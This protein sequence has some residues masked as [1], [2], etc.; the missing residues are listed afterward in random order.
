[1]KKLSIEQLRNLAKVKY[2]V[3]Y[4]VSATG[5][6]PSDSENTYLN[7]KQFRYLRDADAELKMLCSYGFNPKLISA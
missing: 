2:L 5:Y 7:T 1:M 6:P 4:P 3:T